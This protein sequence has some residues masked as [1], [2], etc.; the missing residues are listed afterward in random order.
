MICLSEKLERFIATFYSGGTPL[1][2]G[3]G[4]EA[5]AKPGQN[6][7]GGPAAIVSG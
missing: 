6:C 4:F 2:I 5:P 7:L 1:K 3:R